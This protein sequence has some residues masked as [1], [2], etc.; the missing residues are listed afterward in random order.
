MH[1][2][3]KSAFAFVALAEAAATQSA[4]SRVELCHLLS[5]PRKFDG[6]PVEVT[7]IHIGDIE[8][9][10]LSK[11]ECRSR[12][13]LVRDTFDASRLSQSSGSR[14]VFRGVVRI[15]GRHGQEDLVWLE[16]PVLVSSTKA[17]RRP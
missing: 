8:A 16:N 12:H 13:L 15:V 2:A 14:S 9:S 17:N 5:T 7:G 1:R 3:L 6:R 4:P 11:A 10:Y